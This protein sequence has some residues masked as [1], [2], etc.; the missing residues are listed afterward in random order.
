MF[1]RVIIDFGTLPAR[2]KALADR[3]SLTQQLLGIAEAAR[4]KWTRLA[5]QNLHTSRQAYLLGLQQPA[6][7]EQG[8][9]ALVAVV[10]LSG[11]LANA[12]ERGV[13][14][15]SLLEGLLNG[16]SVRRSKNGASYT[17]VPYRMT[18][19]GTKGRA[20]QPMD[21]VYAPPGPH[22]LSGKTGQSTHLAA[23]IGREVYDRARKLK[24]GQDVGELSLPPL[25][26][27]HT[28]DPFSRL[29]RA[30][31]KGHRHYV[32]FR[33]ASET[34]P[35]KWQ[36]PGFAARNFAAEVARFVQKAGPAALRKYARDLLSPPGTPPAP[37]GGEEG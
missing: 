5:Q 21:A 37:A 12:V 6:F 34:R 24:A 29:T 1:A 23:L 26:P 32:A 30:G 2:V 28:S 17:V 31:G 18:A 16:Q 33:T 19:P 14:P 22:S 25:K 4:A 11:D 9:G 15:Y 3:E 20:G 35:D 8:D 27:G 7:L 36:H 13:E 10:E